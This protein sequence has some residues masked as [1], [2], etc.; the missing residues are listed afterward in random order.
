M[1]PSEELIVLLPK[2]LGSSCQCSK[3]LQIS[4]SII[5]QAGFS[6]KRIPR[7]ERKARA[8]VARRDGKSK[9]ERS[10]VVR[11]YRFGGMGIGEEVTH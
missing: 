11:T 8:R 2:K 4:E 3:E 7:W 6:W 1:D 10:I 9:R 5:V